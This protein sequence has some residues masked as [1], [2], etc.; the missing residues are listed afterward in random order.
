LKKRQVKLVS[1]ATSKNN[2]LNTESEIGSEKLSGMVS[3][4]RCS[5]GEFS[6]IVFSILVISLTI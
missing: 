5:F 6:K 4:A 3:A 1:E 2:L